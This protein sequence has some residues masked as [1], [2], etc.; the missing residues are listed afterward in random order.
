MSL[1]RDT[2]RIKAPKLQVLLLLLKLQRNC[3]LQIK[4]LTTTLIKSQYLWKL[5]H[6][7]IW[8]TEAFLYTQK[9]QWLFLWHIHNNIL[10]APLRQS[11]SI[12]TSVSYNELFVNLQKIFKF[13]LFFH[14]N[15]G[16]DILTNVNISRKLK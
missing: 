13:S 12:I 6:F 5:V 11:T 9:R 3:S 8:E 2:L 10:M 14:H 16:K 1:E 7:G 4:S 15:A